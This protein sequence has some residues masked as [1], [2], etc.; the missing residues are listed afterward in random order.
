MEKELRK[1][2]ELEIAS[3]L[4][5]MFKDLNP[6][7]FGKMEKHIDEAARTLAKRFYKVKQKLMEAARAAANPETTSVTVKASPVAKPKPAARAKKAAAVSKIQKKSTKPSAKSPAKKA[8]PTSRVA[9]KGK[10][11]AGKS[12]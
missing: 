5:G 11:A 9:A 3:S 4:K 1:K 6:A 2:L 7:A 10:R 8:R 12:K